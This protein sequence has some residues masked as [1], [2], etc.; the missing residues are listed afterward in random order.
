MI[1]IETMKILLYT[2]L[3]LYCIDHGTFKFLFLG[4]GLNRHAVYK[5]TDIV[6]VPLEPS[7]GSNVQLFNQLALKPC[8]K[9]HGGNL[10]H[11]YDFQ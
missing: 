1:Y 5:V 7:S 8:P 9:H 3:C 6:L 11:N 2:N 4:R 10:I